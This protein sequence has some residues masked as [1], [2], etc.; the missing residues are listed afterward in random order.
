M[1]LGR[2]SFD[3]ISDP[4]NHPA[5]GEKHC[6]T[7]DLGRFVFTDL[8]AASYTLR[9]AW[10]SSMDSVTVRVDLASGEDRRDLQLV[11]PRGLEI[12]GVIRDN[13]NKAVW[14]AQVDLLPDPSVKPSQRF[15]VWT[16]RQGRFLARGMPSGTFTLVVHPDEKLKSADE[17]PSASPRAIVGIEA[18]THDLDICLAPGAWLRGVVL[19]ASGSPVPN[20][21]VTMYEAEHGVDLA[22]KRTDSEGRFAVML[23]RTRQWNVVAVPLN[24][25]PNSRPGPDPSHRAHADGIAPGGPDI[26]LRLPPR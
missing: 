21:E 16:D 14:R 10:D 17:P 15:N 13:E 23:D 9:T 11:L 12:G 26:E 20:A 3:G 1:A 8:A 19:D 7:D 6:R 18:G 24:A 5:V 22:V 25:P 4:T 2:R